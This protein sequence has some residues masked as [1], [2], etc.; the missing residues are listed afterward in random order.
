MTPEALRPVLFKLAHRLITSA[1][2]PSY[3]SADRFYVNLLILKELELWDEATTLLSS[4]IGQAISNTSL[5]V[6]ELRRDIWKL[7]G[8]VKEEGERAQARII[9][10]ESVCDLTSVLLVVLTL[11]YV[12]SDRNWLEFLSVLDATFTG[13]EGEASAEKAEEYKSDVAKSQQFF[14]QIADKDGLRDRSAPLALLELEK[15]A[16]SHSLSTGPSFRHHIL[17]VVKAL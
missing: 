14:A 16:L 15:R 5:S 12:H 6:D 4:D 8:S 1:A 9:E 2:T 10:K 17:I 13:L 3:L 7:K 11:I